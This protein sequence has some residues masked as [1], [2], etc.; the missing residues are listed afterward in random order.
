MGLAVDVD[1][2]FHPLWAD[3]RD[4][5]FQAWTAAVKIELRNRAPEE[6]AATDASDLPV[7]EKMWPIF[8][9]ARYDA[10][11][12]VEEIPVRLG[13]VSNDTICKP[14]IVRFKG[15]PVSMANSTEILNPDN[16]KASSGAIFDYSSAFRDF[17][18]LAPGEATEAIV[19]RVKPAKNAKSFVS[20][21]ITVTG[22][23]ARP[24][25]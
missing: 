22:V 10:Q 17:S 14:L 25:R 12:G 5:S 8:D 21:E 18:C 16:G 15:E 11:T 2:I 6:A 7:T 19:W 3:A 4:G 13:N 20:F 23:V 1:G 9:P 24:E